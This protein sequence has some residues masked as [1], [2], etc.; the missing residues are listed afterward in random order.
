MIG[1]QLKCTRSEMIAIDVAQKLD[2]MDL[3][4]EFIGQAFR[5]LREFESGGAHI[6]PPRAVR[7][8]VRKIELDRLSGCCPWPCRPR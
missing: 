3:R 1:E 8:P 6:E 5:L 2:E 7:L 4:P